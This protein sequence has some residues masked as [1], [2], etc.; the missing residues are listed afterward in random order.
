MHPLR[1][2][3]WLLTVLLLAPA[4]VAQE[5]SSPDLARASDGAYLVDAEGNAL[6]LYLR[7]DE[8]TSRC[9]ERCAENWP[10]ATVDGEPSVGQGLIGRHVGTIERDDG[11]RQLTYAGWPLYRYAYDQEAGDTYGHRLGDVFYL[12]SPAG[13]RIEG[14]VPE[15]GAEAD[16]QAG[17]GQEGEGDAADGE[18]AE[19]EPQQAD[20]PRMEEGGQIYAANCAMCHGSE[21]QGDIGPGLAGNGFLDQTGGLITTILFGRPNHGMPPFEGQLSD[22][23]VAAVATFVRNA[24]GNDFGPVE[25]EQVAEHR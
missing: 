4:L 8:E 19:G 1:T 18:G 20:L 2:A 5:A 17:G 11:T 12:V 3:A 14:E 24:W 15:D 10:P 23:E 16:A 13:T 25:P 7:D 22:E 21:G 6:Y 9:D